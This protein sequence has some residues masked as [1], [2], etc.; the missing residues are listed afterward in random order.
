MIERVHQLFAH[1]HQRGG[2]ARREIEPA[3]QLLPPRLGGGMNFGRGQVR[4]IRPPGLDRLLHARGIGSETLRQGFEERDARARREFG[5]AHENFA[6]E[7]NARS[8]SAPGQES[9]HSSTR[10]SERADALARRSRASNARP[11]SEIVCSSSPKK[12]VFILLLR[13]P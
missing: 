5:I 12:D 7:R 4:R 1:A 13:D 6:R 8:L 3:K 9:S 10:L 11:R 2:T